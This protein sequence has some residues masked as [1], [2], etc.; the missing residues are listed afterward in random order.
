MDFTVFAI[1]A[2]FTG[3]LELND[4]I[5]TGNDDP[6]R[7]LWALVYPAWNTEEVLAMVNWMR[8]Y[9]STHERKM[10][11]YGF[12]NKPATGSAKAVYNYLRKTNDTEDYNQILSILMNPWTAGQ[13]NGGPKKKIYDAAEKIKGIITYLES[14]WPARSQQTPSE[15]EIQARKE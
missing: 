13:L 10:K 5:L 3:A 6:Q 2:T 11:F 14:Q 9:N 7:A 1:E 8:E 12:D 15:Q 4:Y